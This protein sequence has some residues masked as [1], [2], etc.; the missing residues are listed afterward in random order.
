VRETYTGADR[1]SDKDLGQAGLAVGE[2]L[3]WAWEIDVHT[4]ER[5][6]LRRRVRLLQRQL[7]AVL[8]EH[9]IK[10]ARYCESGRLQESSKP[11][12]GLEPLTYRLQ[13]DCSTS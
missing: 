4:G 7:K 11:E 2:E 6:E 10:H 12:R 9:S 13:G 5:P 3:F 8:H 1:G